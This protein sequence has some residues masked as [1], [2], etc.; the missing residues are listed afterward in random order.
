MNYKRENIFF[1]LAIKRDTPGSLRCRRNFNRL[2]PPPHVQNLNCP[3][4]KH[5]PQNHIGVHEAFMQKKTAKKNKTQ[6]I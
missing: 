2:A 1:S 5:H 4:E 6:Q 3:R